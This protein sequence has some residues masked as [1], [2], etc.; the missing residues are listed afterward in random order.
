M[1]RVRQADA[2][3]R[4][5]FLGTASAT[6]FKKRRK[7]AI[8][9]AGSTRRGA[10]IVSG[11]AVCPA[12]AGAPVPEIRN[13]SMTSRQ[14]FSPIQQE[15]G[16]AP[17][18]AEMDAETRGQYAALLLEAA[19][20]SARSVSAFLTT[21][22]SVDVYIGVIIA[23]TTDEMLLKN[24]PVTLPLL[25]IPIPV[26][27][28][29]AVAPWLI[30]ALHFYLLLQFRLLVRKLTRFRTWAEAIPPFR[31]EELYERVVNFLY[32]LFL[33]WPERAAIRNK[34]FNAG[35]WI[36]LGVIPLGLLLW[37]QLRFL[38]YHDDS[39]ITWL[40]RL[41]LPVE[42]ALLTAMWP[43]LANP[44]MP[45]A[46]RADR[47]LRWTL[48][49]LAVFCSA[50]F[51]FSWFI[52]DPTH[53]YGQ[54]MT[55]ELKEKVLTAETLPPAVRNALKSGDAAKRNSA[56]EQVSGLY[57]QG[58]DLQRANLYAAVLP[59]ADMRAKP[60]SVWIIRCASPQPGA[61]NL[62]WHE[63][64]C[65]TRLDGA[66]LSWASLQGALLN[67]AQLTG[68]KLEHTNL[69][70]A[71][72][73]DADLRGA[74]M[75]GARM[76]RAILSWA[77]LRGAILDEAQLQG[78]KLESANLEAAH[79]SEADLRGANLVGANLSLAILMGAKYDDNTRFPDGFVPASQRMIRTDEEA[80][81]VDAEQQGAE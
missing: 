36:P 38:P 24:T 77:S 27:G 79:L 46:P 63:R 44:S 39:W 25:N 75:T 14:E 22:L 70:D 48:L 9:T 16:S 65:R 53:W 55:L 59:K 15:S 10:S 69:E 28:F 37:A 20:D 80:G 29:Y 72:L 76:Q 1:L 71:D 50:G 45:E 21:F 51:G 23:S 61:E 58:R 11:E 68:A 35:V 17:G 74:S 57:L 26:V 32:A 41:Q 3:G 60:D 43:K 34:L 30:I 81:P 49:K 8:V 2:A 67:E 18:P 52:T 62:S 19:N 64:R 66:D 47:G 73:K 42:I 12:Q 33:A 13:K 5:P 4:K 78:A 56:L 54:M 6:R 40:Q 31:R 7:L